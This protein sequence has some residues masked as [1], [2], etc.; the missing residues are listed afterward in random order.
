MENSNETCRPEFVEV[1]DSIRNELD[2]LETNSGIVINKVCIIRD[3]RQPTK[4]DDNPDKAVTNRGG[5]LGDIDI[6][7]ERLRIVN[8]IVEDTKYGL[9]K[10]VG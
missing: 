1:L 3:F 2:R 9:T 7:V 4:C 8:S 10:F 5:I 6:I